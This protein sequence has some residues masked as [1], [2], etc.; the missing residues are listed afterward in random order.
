M[1]S[2]G[3]YDVFVGY[4]RS[5]EAAAAELNGWLRAQG[6]RTFIYELGNCPDQNLP[7][8]LISIYPPE[9]A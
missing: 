5:D 7:P 4:S 2:D 8:D 1:E 6:L 3:V 9:A